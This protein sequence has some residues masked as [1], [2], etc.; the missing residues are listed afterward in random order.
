V[1]GEN[2]FPL[3][4][5]GLHSPAE[6][7]RMHAVFGLR[8]I[9][10]IEPLTAVMKDPSPL[11]RQLAVEAFAEE[12][13]EECIPLLEEALLAPDNRDTAALLDAAVEGLERLTG[14]TYQKP[15][16]EEIRI[17]PPSSQRTLPPPF[18]P[19]ISPP[20]TGTLRE[21]ILDLI[22]QLASASAQVEAAQRLAEIGEPALD[23]VLG[24]LDGRTPYFAE[25]GSGA[26]RDAADGITAAVCALAEACEEAFLRYSR[27][28]DAHGRPWLSHR[29]YVCGLGRIGSYSA[30]PPLLQA[31][32]AGDEWV[33]HAAAQALAWR[34][35]PALIETYL[36]M[37]RSAGPTLRWHGAE[38]LARTG[39]KEH[40]KVLRRASDEKRNREL[41]I[42]HQWLLEEV[43][44]MSRRLQGDLDGD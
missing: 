44:R 32:R 15:R 19:G 23:T 4:C 33:R 11:I 8:A 25:G 14:R 7:V 42:L 39:G 10:R 26:W 28:T 27:Y 38:G 35:E 24:V 18:T 9:H 40:L 36:R 22:R 12:G 1:E 37:L 6:D 20:P 17:R 21:S 30:V 13:G 29:E 5:S 43:E 34:D 3:L 31:L 16:P 41:P 2:A